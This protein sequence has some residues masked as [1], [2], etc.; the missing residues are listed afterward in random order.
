M[1]AR[2]GKLEEAEKALK[3]A[4]KLWA[5]SLL[6]LRLRPDWEGAAPLFERAALAFKVRGGWCCCCCGG[7]CV[8]VCEAGWV[9]CVVH[10]LSSSFSSPAV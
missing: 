10:C 1:A 8:C 6:D 7:V 4:N 5:P 3:Q 9:F 2:A